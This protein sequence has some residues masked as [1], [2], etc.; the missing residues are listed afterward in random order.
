MRKL[1][2]DP[3]DVEEA[4]LNPKLIRAMKEGKAPLEYLVTSVLAGDARVHKTG[5][6]KYGIFNWRQDEILASTYKG[7]MLRHLLAWCEGE[8]LDP[9]SGE[10]HLYHLRAC[11]AVVLDSQMQDT[12][13][14]DRLRTESKDQG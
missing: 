14:D 4:K 10:N 12:L 11:C 6:D 3:P 5:G 8:D 13:I 7:A 1:L 2:S 9:E